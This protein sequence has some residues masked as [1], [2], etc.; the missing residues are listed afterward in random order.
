MTVPAFDETV[1]LFIGGESVP[2]SDG[3]TFVTEDPATE[4]RLADVASAG[5]EDVDRAVASAREGFE[6]W[7]ALEPPERGRRLLAV[8]DAIRDHKEEL[9]EIETLD[10]GKPIS[11][12]R[13]SV[14]TAARYI[15]FYA[16]LADK[17]HGDT[18]PVDGSWNSQT[19]PEPYGVSAQVT[20]WNYP[21]T[22]I[23]RGAGP[24]LAA[25]NAVVGKPASPTPLTTVRVAQ[26][27]SEAGLPDGVLNAIPGS[28]Q[29]A[30]DPLVSH[31]DVDVVTF[32]G[33]RVT[34]QRIMESA[35]TQMSPVTLEL[36]G[37]SPAVVFEDADVERVVDSLLLGILRNAGQTCSA[38]SRLLVHESLEEQVVDRFVE[39]A[40]EYDLGPGVD[41]PD[42]G[43]LV[44][45]DQFETVT[46]YI[47]LG[48]R[49]G[50][51]LRA[52]GGSSRPGYFVEPTVFT[53]VAHDMRIAQEE[54]FG[55]VL[56]VST[57][58][59]EDEAVELANDV[60]YG[61]VAGVFTAE[62]ERANRVAR[63]IDAGQVYVNDWFAGGVETPF[64][65]YKD[66]GIG[67]EKGMQAVE[68][69]TQLKT[70]NSRSFRRD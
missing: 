7:Q 58:A 46:E 35:A 54:I 63:A 18:I 24:A 45:E 17:I 59:D 37:K 5:P 2:A 65:G 28:G 23:T 33:S 44:S 69:Y 10:Q 68:E 66:S 27:A 42:M 8:A 22:Q 55:P 13:G 67:R 57:F 6:A 43:P 64:G 52:G 49:E 40:G 36:G 48:Q 12:A 16:G 1:P 19:I 53:D 20:P 34:G 61:L 26:I 32:T 51:T 21:I 39:R 62:Y 15:E 31:R 60:D 9:A 50:A 25:G 4:E 56:T 3:E 14:E 47:D 11:A 29:D 38:A 41:D 70:I 30:G